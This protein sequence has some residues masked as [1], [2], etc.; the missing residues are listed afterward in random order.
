MCVKQGVCGGADRRLCA[1]YDCNGNYRPMAAY[2]IQWARDRV[3]PSVGTGKATRI[4]RSIQVRYII[5]ACVESV[6]HVSLNYSIDNYIFC[7]AVAV[8]V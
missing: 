2:S 8:G 7:I 4:G 1:E 6:R 5:I 3:Q